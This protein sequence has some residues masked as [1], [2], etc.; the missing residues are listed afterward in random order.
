MPARYSCFRR[1]QVVCTLGFTVLALLILPAFR[2]EVTD[3][4]L[5]QPLHRP[6]GAC[7]GP[8]L[9]IDL[10]QAQVSPNRLVNPGFEDEGKWPFEAGVRE[11]QVP[12]GWFAFWRDAPP[13]GIPLPSNCSRR[14]DASCYWARPE[15]RE[16]KATEFPNRVHSGARALKYFSF[17]RMH[18]AGLYQVVEGIP[19]DARLRFSVWL[20]TWM[21]GSASACQGGKVSDAPA[22]MHLQ[23]GIDPSGSIDPWSPQVIWSPEGE[24][25]DR[26]QRFHVDASSETGLATVFVRSRAEWDWPR[27]NNDVYVDDASLI[28][29]AEPTPAP[30][31]NT[32]PGAQH[33]PTPA[34]V[35]AITHTVVAGETLGSIAL[36][37]DI[38]IEQLMRLNR[39]PPGQAILPGQVLVING[40][41]SISP[42]LGP[43]LQSTTMP[44]APLTQNGFAWGLGALI[45]SAMVAWAFTTAQRSQAG[46]RD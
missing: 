20:Q 39:L 30:V 31:S 41:E 17:G 7:P 24:T 28:I 4:V 14:Q 5:A 26:W 43:T 22:R 12:P 15:F 21:C 3:H 44:S 27:L 45:L 37:Y 19:L 35:R 8:R 6:Q 13:I 34:L 38:S 29:L 1:W 42:T 32:L 23:I 25:F 11:I 46:R 36:T 18:E 9:G 33:I 16:V 2:V 40:S 10:A